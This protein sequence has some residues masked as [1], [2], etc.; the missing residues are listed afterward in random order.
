MMKQ[1]LVLLGI[2]AVI[3]MS[4]DNEASK[5]GDDLNLAKSVSG[6]Y[7]GT[8]TNSAT[9]QVRDATLTVTYEN[10]SLISLHCEADDFDSTMT[11]QIYQNYDSVMICST[12]DDFY[13]MYG[14]Q[15]QGDKDFSHSMDQ[16]WMNHNMNCSNCW[17][18]NDQWNAWTNHMNTQHD[19]DDRHYGGFDTES[20]TGKLDFQMDEGQNMWFESF[21]GVKK[22]S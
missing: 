8:L 21:R 16:S 10:D 4:C 13:R 7:S 9:G 5:L 12:G 6:V 22:S 2:V 11:M 15:Y 18:G 1:V 19:N 3:S 17:A 14:H 20:H